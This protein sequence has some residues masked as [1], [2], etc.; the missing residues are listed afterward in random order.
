M[1]LQQKLKETGV[2]GEFSVELKCD[3][4]SLP[5]SLFKEIVHGLADEFRVAIDS[6]GVTIYSDFYEKT[7]SIEQCLTLATVDEENRKNTAA[8]LRRAADV[9]SGPDEFGSRIYLDLQP[10]IKDA[11]NEQCEEARQ[12]EYFYNLFDVRFLFGVTDGRTFSIIEGMTEESSRDLIFGPDLIN[13]RVNYKLGQ[14]I[15]EEEILLD[16]ISLKRI[17]IEAR[18]PTD[19]I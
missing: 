4:W 8:F 1:D 15:M 5:E 6:A 13:R 3:I 14:F 12:A 7:F 18:Q 11:I 16:D 19:N 2:D 10:K 9:L 17:E